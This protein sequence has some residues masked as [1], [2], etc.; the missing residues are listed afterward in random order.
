MVSDPDIGTDLLHLHK[1]CKYAK[2]NF[3]IKNNCSNIVIYMPHH[4]EDMMYV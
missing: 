1:I 3:L 2:V 4:T